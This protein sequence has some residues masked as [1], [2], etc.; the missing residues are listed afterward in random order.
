MLNQT[1][2]SL[3]E[4]RL[5]S[6]GLE[7]SSDYAV[8]GA[9]GHEDKRFRVG[10]IMRLSK[11]ISTDGNFCDGTCTPRAFSSLRNQ[12]LIFKGREEKGA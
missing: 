1:L 5:R 9:I 7:A 11:W 12:R 2:D 6:A 10:H 3:G 8:V 4:N